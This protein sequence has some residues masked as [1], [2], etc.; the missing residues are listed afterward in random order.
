MLAMSVVSTSAGF[1]EAPD[2][3]EHEADAQLA[4]P[5]KIALYCFFMVPII[6]EISPSLPQEEYA[7]VKQHS[8]VCQAPHTLPPA[9]AEVIFWV[10]LDAFVCNSLVEQDLAS[11]LPELDSGTLGFLFWEPDP[12]EEHASSCEEYA[13]VADFMLLENALLTEA[14]QSASKPSTHLVYEVYLLQKSLPEAPNFIWQDVIPLWSLVGSQ[15]ASLSCANLAT[16][17]H[18]VTNFAAILAS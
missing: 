12:E 4:N 18:A 14:G 3:E 8:R 10:Q 13:A 17:T 6:V 16:T 5:G 11:S 1:A 2:A 15:A 7:S 9:A